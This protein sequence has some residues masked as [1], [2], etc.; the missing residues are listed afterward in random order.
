M[1]WGEPP[2]REPASPRC[3]LG[4]KRSHVLL[5]T[6][7]ARGRCLGY[8]LGTARGSLGVECPLAARLGFSVLPAA[9]GRRGSTWSAG[10]GA[11]GCWDSVTKA[12]SPLAAQGGSARPCWAGTPFKQ[13][14]GV[15]RDLSPPSQVWERTGLGAPRSWAPRAAPRGVLSAF[16]ARAALSLCQ[17]LLPVLTHGQWKRS[18]VCTGRSLQ[19]RGSPPAKV[20][21]SW[22]CGEVAGV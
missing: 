11:R 10:S 6:K 13:S 15:S 2:I 8:G 22:G 1:G 21:A 19:L 5:D 17:G 18:Q 4:Q 14:L 12:R 20:I 9:V 7:P 3:P 16:S